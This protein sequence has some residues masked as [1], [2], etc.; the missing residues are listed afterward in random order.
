MRLRI[1]VVAVLAVLVGFVTPGSALAAPTSV[2]TTW[3]VAAHQSNLTEI[4]AGKAAGQKATSTG[5][6][7]AGA[8]F[9]TMHTDLDAKL[10]AAAQKLGVTLPAAP[11]AAQQATLARVGALSGTAFDTAWVA[12]QIAGHREAIAA[13]AKELASGSDTAVLA[14]AK[15]AAPVI[16]S[17][18]VTVE[19]LAG[20]PVTVQAGTGGQAAA[21]S[22]SSASGYQVWILL[23]TGLV[24]AGAGTRRITRTRTRTRARR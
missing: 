17:H 21:V 10:T 18:L 11:T 24:L 15:A 23:L 13:T 5:V 6:K 14:L 20:V 1:F 4:A 16:A 2:D 7:D 3:M 22:S 9:V 8:M 12:S 19:K